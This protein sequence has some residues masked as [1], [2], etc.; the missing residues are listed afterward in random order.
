MKRRK[1]P[2]MTLLNAAGGKI[3]NIRLWIKKLICDLKSYKRRNIK[4]TAPRLIA[5]NKYPLDISVIVCTYNRPKKLANAVKS[6]CGQTLPSEKY[7]IIIVNNG[8]ELNNTFEEYNDCNIKIIKEERKGLTYARNLGASVSN[9]KYLVYIDDDAIAEPRLLETI[10]NA[11]D[12][13]SNAGIIGGQIILK[14]PEPKPNIILEGKETLWSEYT[15]PYTKYREINKQ[16][17][18]PFGANFS[19]RHNIFNAVG[20]FDESYG[21]VGNNY[22]GGEETV[23]CF[24]VLNCGCKIGIEP[25]AVVYHDVDKTRYTKE[26][27]KETIKAGIFTTYRL[28]KDGYS[29]AA[30]DKNYALERIKIAEREIEKLIKSNADELELY[31]KECEKNG[32]IELADSI[33]E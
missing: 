27:I 19:V 25:K 2:T 28:Y 20:G 3:I 12:A 14:T 16:Y 30:W 4:K 18:F 11:F 8:E 31:Y 23:L 17:E 6:L 26:H 9:G 15:V 29:P 33:C 24:K 21:R 10:K 1:K 32:F 22:A 7:E 13:H 5:D